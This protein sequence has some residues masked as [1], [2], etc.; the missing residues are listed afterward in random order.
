M[1]L[2]AAFWKWF[3]DS[4]VVDASG[5][6]L[7]VYHGS[8][9]HF[10]AFKSRENEYF[11][12]NS[13]QS[14]KDYGH[15]LY[16]VFLSIS[17]PLIVDFEGGP[18]KAIFDAIDTAKGDKCD[19]VIALNTHDGASNLDQYVVFDPRQI[20]SVDNDGTWDKHD[21]NVKSN[22]VQV[23][24]DDM[25]DADWG[26]EE[27]DARYSKR[28]AAAKRKIFS[29]AGDFDIVAFASKD[30]R[31]LYLHQTS[32]SGPNHWQVSFIAADGI[33]TMDTIFKK[34]DEALASIAGAG[35]SPNI[36]QPGE[37]KVTET[38]NVRGR[39]RRSR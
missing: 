10:S 36:G 1:K 39:A 17:N 25:D 28:I 3:G 24:S 26:S 19:G 9:Y 32:N 29:E 11:F 38:R 23:Y 2:N 35:L 27:W 14:T 33:P 21:R 20:K 5:N 31:V 15:I 34:R 12:A 30:G 16:S 6:P 13:A 8:P 18:D 7:V 4:K 22:P 37:W